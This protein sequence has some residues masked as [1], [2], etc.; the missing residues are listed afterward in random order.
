MIIDQ[1]VMIEAPL[2]RCWDIIVDIPRVATCVP[3]VESISQVDETTYVGVLVAK[4]GP[5]TI[6]L[7]G[8][9]TIFERDTEAHRA[10]LRVEATDRRIRGAVNAITQLQLSMQDGGTDLSI[11]TDVSILGKLG[12]FG[13]AVVKRKSDQIMAEF[14]RN[15]TDLL[16]QPQ[17][18]A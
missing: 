5:V 10:S 6:R 18:N 16:G 9:V 1:H 12:Q 14:A 8:K 4:V 13:S 7:E 2:D 11:R 17:A 15:L 3:G